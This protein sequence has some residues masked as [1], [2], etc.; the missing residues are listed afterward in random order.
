MSSISSTS[1]GQ[2]TPSL[3]TV[4]TAS[5]S[6]PPNATTAPVSQSQSLQVSD[7]DESLANSLFPGSSSAGTTAAF[8][9]S[10]ASYAS[11]MDLPP[12]KLTAQSQAYAN[13]KLTQVTNQLAEELNKSSAELM[14]SM[15]D[16]ARSMAE[17]A[18]TKAAENTANATEQAQKQH[19]KHIWGWIGKALEVVV[20]AALI[21]TGVGVGIG[22]MMIATAAVGML[23]KIP[24]V[25]NFLDNHPVVK[26]A[27]VVAMAVGAACSGSGLIS[28]G[29]L[30]AGTAISQ[31]M[32]QFGTEINQALQN[33][34]WSPKAIEWFTIGMSITGA[35]LAVS[36]G[37]GAMK[38]AKASFEVSQSVAAVAK[39]TATVGGLGMAACQ[40]AEGSYGIQIG[41]LQKT[42]GEN[43]ALIQLIH[44]TVTRMQDHCANVA[45]GLSKE[46]SD[47]NQNIVATVTRMQAQTSDAQMMVATRC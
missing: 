4:S 39:A 29:L 25:S 16:V 21:A 31:T 10:Q 38:G 24:A 27:L 42:F 17:V 12:A 30:L 23:E 14:S 15:G 13:I 5:A 43:D 37:V 44:S 45:S 40:I 7:A 28:G 9:T 19:K 6:P 1:S 22:A 8:G 18:T 32:S 41:K 2:Y 3:G 20:G 47:W 36:G 34:G 33:A 35:V 26:G 11:Y 46:I